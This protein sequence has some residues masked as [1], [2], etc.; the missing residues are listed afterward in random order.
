MQ[1]VR[2]S[3]NEWFKSWDE[4]ISLEDRLTRVQ[5]SERSGASVQTIKSLQTDWM[6]QNS[7]KW[8]GR[9]FKRFIYIYSSS[10]TPN[11]LESGK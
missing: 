9:Y 1:S 5:L 11:E 2:R 7:V 8:D 10:L 4:I 6:Q 3:S